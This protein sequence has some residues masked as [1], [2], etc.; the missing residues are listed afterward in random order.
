VGK[1][2]ASRNAYRHGLTLNITS[3]AAFAKT[4]GDP[5]PQNRRRQRVR[6]TVAQMTRLIDAFDRG[7]PIAPPIDA[8]ATMPSQEPDRSAEAIRR[9]LPQLRKLERYE[10]R[11]AA[12]RERAVLGLSG[13]IKKRTQF[14]IQPRALG[15][16]ISDEFAVP[17]CRGHHRAVHR[18]RDERAWWREAG[19][20]PIKVARRLWKE[21]RGLGQRRSRRLA[22][23]RLHDA[24][25]P[26]DPKNEDIAATA[27]TQETRLP[28]VPG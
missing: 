2:L 9:V 15:R 26:S 11:A 24:G 5:R 19:I 6:L 18:S 10:R 4:A 22:L 25:A 7:R 16:K 13:R 23:T 17:L 14:F 28:N 20:D 21:T 3:T 12:Q 8:T 27:E 1:K